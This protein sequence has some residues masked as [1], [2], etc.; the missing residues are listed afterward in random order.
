MGQKYVLATIAILLGIL[1]GYT[2]I[3]A[4]D[5]IVTNTIDRLSK[6]NKEYRT[7]A[8]N[9]G[10]ISE[11]RRKDTAINGQKP[12]A[13]VITCSDSRLVPEHIFNAGIGDLFVI[14]TAGNVI[15]EF[16]LGS[17][18]YGAE[19]LYA[20]TIVVMGHT[21]CGAVASAI[22]DNAHGNIKKITDEIKEGIGNEKDSTKAEIKNLKHSISQIETSDTIRKLIEEKKVRIQGAIYNIDTGKVDFL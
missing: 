3:F 13:V 18:E 4:K 7:A 8:Y 16:E 5:D 17:I 1:A 11:E 14:R 12:Y 21:G 15:G 2:N 6:G 10:D 19:H 20:D 9:S 22:Q